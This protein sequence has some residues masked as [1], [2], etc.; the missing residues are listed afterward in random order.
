QLSGGLSIAAGR[1]VTKKLEGTLRISGTQSH[2]AGSTLRVEQG[3]VQL[4]SNAGSAATAAT[5]AGANLALDISNGGGAASVVLGSHQ[6]LKEANVHFDQSDV[7]GLD[8]NSPATPGGY[9]ALRVYASDLDGTRLA[10]SNAVN[11]AKT[12]AGD[13]V[14]DSG[15]VN[16]PGSA[17]GVAVVNDAHGD[18]M[19]RVSTTR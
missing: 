1:V 15:L 10:M 18:K 3:N 2:G 4:N 11:N 8:L 19:V 9:N 14:F 13:G 7:Q 17:I 12:N 16:H 6:D 5:A